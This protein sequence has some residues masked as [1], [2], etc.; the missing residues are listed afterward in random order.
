MRLL[1]SSLSA[2]MPENY[3][4]AERGKPRPQLASISGSSHWD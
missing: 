3:F 1:P 2:V 4:C